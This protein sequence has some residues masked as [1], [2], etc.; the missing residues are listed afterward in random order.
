MGELFLV[1]H[2]QAAF[3]TEDYDRLTTLGRR[4]AEWLGRYFLE[5]DMRFGRVLCGTLRRHQQ[6]LEGI[7]S[8]G[9]GLATAEVDGR[10]DEYDPQRLVSAHLSALEDARTEPTAAASAGDSESARKVHFRLLRDA[11]TAWTSGNIDPTVHRSFRTFQDDAY[12]AF[13]T[14]CR[15]NG[16]PVARVLVVSSGGP[17]SSI[18]AHHLGMPAASFVALNLQVRNSG[19]CEFR[20]NARAAHL[21]SFNNVPHLDTPDRRD[22]ITFS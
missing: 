22:H 11:L 5:R 21:V 8:Q 6:T 1:R 18:I 14:A 17:I 7:G 13:K 12:G 4:Q 19:F 15:E 16:S 10:L 20:F 3:G 9:V 2:A